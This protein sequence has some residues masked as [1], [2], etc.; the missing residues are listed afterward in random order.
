MQARIAT[1]RGATPHDLDAFLP[2]LAERVERDL[3]TPGLEGLREI[4]VLVDREHG[5][6]LSLTFFDNEDDLNRAEQA[7]GRVAMTQ[8]GAVRTEVDRYEVVLH[9]SR[10]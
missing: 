3:D 4:L 5:R 7:L 10:S 9:Q 1:Y 8:A 2:Q 6:A